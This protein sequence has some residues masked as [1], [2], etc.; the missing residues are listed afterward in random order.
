[1]YKIL[2]IDENL[3]VVEKKQGI[4]VQQDKSDG[5]KGLIEYIKEEYGKSCELCHRLDRNTGGIVLIARNSDTLDLLTA[6]IKEKKIVKSYKAVLCGNLKSKFPS[7]PPIGGFYT[8]TAWHFKDAKKSLVYI[9]DFPKKFAKKIITEF[10]IINYNKTNDTTLVEVRLITGRT[11]QI[12]AQFSHLGFPVA[13]DG[14]YGRNAV[15]KKL[16]Y[17]N[18]ALWA[19]KVEL[20]GT[21]KHTEI[22]EVFLSDPDFR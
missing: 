3:I 8:L 19:Y 22:P 14:K 1:M 21:L 15:N 5:E 11:H 20:R 16:P 13:G 17:K 4:A 6:A 12:R 10:K 7:K 2:Y 9:Y 18:Q